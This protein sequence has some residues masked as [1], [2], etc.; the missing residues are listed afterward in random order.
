MRFR[1][2]AAVCSATAVAVGATVAPGAV[3]SGSAGVELVARGLDNPRGLDVSRTGAVF[4]AEAGKAGPCKDAGGEKVCFGFNGSITQIMNGKKTKVASGFISLGEKD[5]SFT[6]GVDDVAV[7]PSGKVWAIVTDAPVPAKVAAEIAGKKGAGQ[8]GRAFRMGGG[9]RTAVAWVG[10]YER[11]HNPDGREMNPNPYSIALAGD[12]TLVTD[13][14]GNTLLSISKSGKVSL[15]ALIPQIT[16]GK[17][18][19][20]AVP[21]AVAVGPD[22]AYYV[23]ELGGEGT[24]K[25][26]SR[27]WRIEPGKKPVVFARGFS[28][29]VGIDFDS[30]GNL[31]V[32]QLVNDMAKAEKGDLTG[33]L[34]KVSPQGER[35]ELAKGKLKALGGVA[36]GP[37]DSVYASVQSVFAGRGRVV[38]ITQ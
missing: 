38:R 19:A 35:T 32:A 17:K 20:E 27:V 7:E 3:G 23:G 24:P 36:V 18:G 28:N 29:I 30:G 4:V 25:R 6:V 12:R 26:G 31:Y 11:M 22:G 1:T 10:S 13:A 8:L 21:T 9:T 14:G 2:F 15:V 16:P 37:D 34:L 33:A 5:G